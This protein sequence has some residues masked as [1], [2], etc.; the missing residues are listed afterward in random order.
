MTTTTGHTEVQAPDDT[1][2]SSDTAP[3]RKVDDFLADLDDV[4]A[5]QTAPAVPASEPAPAEAPAPA[6]PPP[7]VPTASDKDWWDPL[8]RDDRADQDTFTGN[9]PDNA[10]PPPPHPPAVPAQ[11]AAD[12]GHDDDPEEGE[13]DDE[14]TDGADETPAPGSKKKRRVG[15]AVLAKVKSA[16]GGETG[17]ADPAEDQDDE[18]DEDAVT[19]VWRQA[20]ALKALAKVEGR[21]RA[22]LLYLPGTA[23]AWGLDWHRRVIA[24]MDAGYVAPDGLIGSL[25]GLTALGGGLWLAAR[26]KSQLLA[27]TSL[28][29]AGVGYAE[30]GPRTV[31]YM[32]A[33]GFDP[34]IVTP[35]GSAILAGALTWWCIDRRTAHWFPPLA[36]VM[37]TPTAAI[38]LALIF[39]AA[40]TL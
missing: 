16:K 29:V 14:E 10:P 38:G 36:C 35:V 30:G 4:L 20:K 12:D 25:I 7:T 3:V 32:T 26:K 9:L 39:Y 19:R 40:P 24:Y 15:S 27:V 31:A 23:L 8:Y 28:V 33:H 18:D 5:E 34:A 11:A 13:P 37:R 1:A 21:R 6:E 22:A 2:E 17:D